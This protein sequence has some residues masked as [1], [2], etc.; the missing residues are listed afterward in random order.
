MMHFSDLEI[1][2][3]NLRRWLDEI[4]H[5]LFTLDKPHTS[6]EDAHRKLLENQVSH[7]GTHFFISAYIDVYL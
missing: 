3:V 4:E 6:D 1:D 7:L 5:R 2:I